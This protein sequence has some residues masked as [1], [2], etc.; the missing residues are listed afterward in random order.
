MIKQI[1]A[2]L[3]PQQD[4][5]IKEMLEEIK[6]ERKVEVVKKTTKKSTKNK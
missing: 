5:F 1:K 2:W 6:P 3:F 4:K